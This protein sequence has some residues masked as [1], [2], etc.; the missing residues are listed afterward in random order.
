MLA[1]ISS[2]KSPAGQIARVFR[3]L[4]QPVR[5]RILLTIGE[6]EACVCHLEAHLG[7]RQALISQHL[8]VLR[9]AG[10]VTA[11]RDGRNI[12]YRL[13]GAELLD[14]VRQA[15][16][17]VGLPADELAPQRAP[18]AACPCPRCNRQNEIDS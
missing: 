13:A 12:Y 18:L 3:I 8:M 1:N 5:V 17:L 15:A 14:V 7:L 16:L 6:G 4:G 9:D 11:E 10:L 2:R